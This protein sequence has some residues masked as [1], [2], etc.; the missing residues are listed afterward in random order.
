VD[1]TKAEFLEWKTSKVTKEVLALLDN[2][3]QELLE[4]MGD[5][6]TLYTEH[7]TAKAVGRVQAYKDLINIEWED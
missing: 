2:M 4:R 7:D 3:K 5:G 6:A 1:I